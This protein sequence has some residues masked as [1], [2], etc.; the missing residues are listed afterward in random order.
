MIAA[1]ATPRLSVVV[2]TFQRREVLARTLPTMLDPAMPAG[3]YEIVVVVDGSTDGTAEMLAGRFAGS[4]RTLLRANAGPAAARNTGIQAARGDIILFLDDDL[5]CPS[6]L[7][8]AHL[9]A[10]AAGPRAVFGP[11]LGLEGGG[12]AAAVSRIALET[13]YSRMR[14]CWDP[15]TS[16]TAYVAPNT[17]VPRE[18]LVRAGGFDTRF[19]RA[20]ED[21][22][23]GLRLR[24]AGLPFMYLPDS[25]VHQLYT[26]DGRALA[27]VDA[28]LHGAGEVLLCRT[29]PGQ[30]RHSF[31]AR[32]GEGSVPRRATRAACARSPLPAEWL[33][34]P[35]SW[36]AEQLPFSEM[37]RL[38]LA[39]LS[40]RGYAAR[41]RAA[42]AAGGGWPALVREF[43][44]R[45]PAL[46]YHHVG[47]AQP[48]MPASLTVAPGQFE[49]QMRF[50]HRRG[51]TAISARRW[52]DWMEA[53][54]PL[55]P[56]PF[57]LTFDD[58][59]ADLAEHAFPVLRRLGFSA[60]VFVV[61]GRIGGSND[62]DAPV[63]APVH[64]LLDRESLVKWSAEGMEFGSHTNTHARLDNDSALPEIR[65][66]RIALE[67]VLQTEVRTFAYPWG[68]A[69]PAARVE[70]ASS[71]SLAF[72]IG[73][74][75]NT[76]ATDPFLQ[77]RT[78]VQCSDT[79]LDLELRASIGW[80]PPS[81]MRSR[82][83]LRS[84]VRTLLLP[85]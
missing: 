22:D 29:H 57:I 85:R 42:A 59:Y 7:L 56:R 66:S 62:W 68:I 8:T 78:M 72:G 28:A 43:G 11:V 10:H 35:V 36:I 4:V 41:L 80:S 70:A 73:D 26:K 14:D 15:N 81:W 74:G 32:A 79:L 65:S 20:H 39:L 27:S 53:A 3:S 54:V 83:R 18:V 55:P 40:R 46:L 77:R 9:E 61:A 84:R 21:A 49:R 2:P 64:R 24:A 25:P 30:R 34:R 47:P 52:L 5:L 38:R 19:A 58:G 82:L 63:R 45:C 13:Y 33:L 1:T 17:S 71:Y 51:Y 76:L 75:V 44:Q 6:G 67:D 23:L 16:P 69:P 50:L 60:T 31:L 37:H 48:G 12:T